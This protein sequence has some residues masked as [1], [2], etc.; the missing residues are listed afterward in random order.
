MTAQPSEFTT[1]N[2]IMDR[3]S[4]ALWTQLADH[5]PHQL[6][7]D[8]IAKSAGVDVGAAKAVAGS[9]TGLILHRLAQLDQMAAIES[10]ADIEDAGEVSIREKIMEAIMHRFEIYAP[11]KAQIAQLDSAARRDPELAIRLLDSLV[12]AMR[13]ILLM[14]GDDLVGWRGAARVRGVA[15]MSMLVAKVWQDDETPDLSS[16]MKAI[17]HRLS[18][19][20]EWGRTFRVF[21]RNADTPDHDADT[22]DHDADTPDRDDGMPDADIDAER[23]YNVPQDERYQ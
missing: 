23:S 21:D 15:A 8:D 13:R 17:D 22:P 5:P 9:V 19:A 2:E 18:Q 12:Q 4:L 3:L 10:F 6:T 16:T 20:E 1:M 7:I 14:V 11:Y